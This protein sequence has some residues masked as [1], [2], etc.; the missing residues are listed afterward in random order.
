MY[1]KNTS[2]PRGW[3]MAYTA[4]GKPYYIDHNTKTT[5][6]KP[7]QSS[8]PGY[9]RGRGRG[10]YGARRGID[11]TKKKTKLCMYW[12]K[13]GTCV[14]G[15]ECAFAHGTAQLAANSSNEKQE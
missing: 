12:E 7:P 13:N 11:K 10:G 6:W 14:Y 9:S 8:G 15:D 2:L 1:G 4:E 5:H 3:E